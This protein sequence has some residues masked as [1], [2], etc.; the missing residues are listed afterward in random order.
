MRCAVSILLVIVLVTGP[1]A[2]R[3]LAETPEKASALSEV[4][5]RSSKLAFLMSLVVPG[6]GELYYGAEK[7]GIA[8]LAVEAGSWTTYASWLHRG[9]TIERGF[10]A[11]ADQHWSESSY[12]A[13]DTNT[14]QS[15]YIRTEHLPTKQED[16][17]QYYELIG[18]YDQFVFGWDDGK[19]AQGKLVGT[20]YSIHP[21]KVISA[22]RLY[23]EGERNRSNRYLKRATG[24]LGLVVVNHLASAVD[25]SIHARGQHARL[26]VDADVIGSTEPVPAMLLNVRF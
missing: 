23:Y 10:R 6:L 17:Q 9:R 20:D 16:T 3:G 26:W 22:N 2:S 19:D 25:A 24:I 15:F 8:F 7:R 12:R 4:I 1:L 13:W 14:P 5:G 18:K 21:S 11:F